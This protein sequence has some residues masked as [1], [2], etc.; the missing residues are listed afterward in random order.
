MALLGYEG[1]IALEREAPDPLMFGVDALHRRTNSL[2]SSD[3]TFW[4]GDRVVLFGVNGIP[5]DTVPSGLAQYGDANRWEVGPTRVHIADDNDS[6]YR[7]DDNALFYEQVP[8]SQVVQR[9]VYIG[10]DIL[11]RISFY[12]DQGDA[13]QGREGKRIQIAYVDWD[14]VV[15]FPYGAGEYANAVINSFLDYDSTDYGSGTIIEKTLGSFAGYYP[16]NWLFICEMREWSLET[17]AAAV[18]TTSVGVKFG[19][20]VK[21]LVTGSGSIDFFVDRTASDW[22]GHKL[23]QLVLMTEKGC[24]ANAQFILLLDQD[25][26]ACSER[27]PGTLYYEADV[28]LTACAVSVR[29]E[30]A[31]IG[32]ARFV[33]T[34]EITLKMG[35]L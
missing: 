23:M 15:M 32:S 16:P 18:D 30:D 9:A 6:F 10:R 24:K 1:R 33:T 19:E 12:A 31:I 3:N 20:S 22:S 5:T 4:S 13:L 27:L 14:K 17:D 34:G 26:G 25:G 29:I 28:L 2:E 21:S 8:A 35:T 7:T 11:G